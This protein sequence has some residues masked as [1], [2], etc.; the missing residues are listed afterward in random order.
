MRNLL[1]ILLLSMAPFS[2]LAQVEKK[3]PATRTNKNIQQQPSVTTVKPTANMKPIQQIPVI[4]EAELERQRA[5]NW[6]APF[7]N[8]G[9]NGIDQMA[10]IKTLDLATGS[11]TINGIPRNIYMADDSLVHLKAFSGLESLTVPAWMTNNGLQ[12]V[13]AIPSLKALYMMN[14]KVNDQ[15]M[16]SLPAMPNIETL[17]LFG[18]NVSNTF[19]STYRQQFPN[20]FILNIG[21]TGINDDGLALILPDHHLQKLILTRGNFTD[22]CIPTIMQ[23]NALEFIQVEFT[24]ITSGGRDQLK[25][26]F[27]NATVVP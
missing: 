22:A 27:P 13:A 2:L 25:A 23:L 5:F 7:K 4:D 18:T 14:S 1:L 26:A 15:G 20:V 9:M 12:H 3:D 8:Y 21:Q 11:P 16:A 17:V 10:N 19:M 6:I 24:Q